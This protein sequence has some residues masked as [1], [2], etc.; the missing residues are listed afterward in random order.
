MTLNSVK[1][2]ALTEI[3]DDYN[4]KLIGEK[5][6]KSRNSENGV[7]TYDKIEHSTNGKTYDIYPIHFPLED[8]FK[9]A[10]SSC[11]NCYGKGYQIINLEKKKIPDPSGFLLMEEP[12][13]ENLSDEQK[14]LWH[15]MQANKKFWR[16]MKP[17]NCAVKR[18]FKR[19]SDIFSNGLHSIFV[20]VDYD[21]REEKTDISEDN[22]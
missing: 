17:C 18:L 14:K 4:F 15:E 20:K 9:E 3:I 7:T 22:A 12:E 8:V 21:V 2:P 16:I 1:K 11:N 6:L 19:H 10:N 5:I 13:P